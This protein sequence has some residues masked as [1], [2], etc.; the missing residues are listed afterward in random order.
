MQRGLIRILLKALVYVAWD[1]PSMDL[2]EWPFW[3]SSI[4]SLIDR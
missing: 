3:I 4:T 1:V 2:G